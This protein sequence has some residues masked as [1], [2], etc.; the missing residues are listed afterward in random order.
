MMPEQTG[1]SEVVRLLQQICAEYEAGSRGLS[2]LAQ[3][4]S[5]HGFITQRMERMEELHQQLHT[6]IGEKATMLVVLHI[7]QHPYP[8]RESGQN[9]TRGDDISR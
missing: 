8:A 6:L 1:D 5:Q 4:V 9:D 7:D 2:G 3:G